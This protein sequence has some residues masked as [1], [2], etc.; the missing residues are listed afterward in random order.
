MIKALSGDLKYADPATR[1][2]LPFPSLIELPVNRFLWTNK[3]GVLHFEFMGRT[4]FGE[5]KTRTKKDN[6]TNAL[7]TLYVYGT[8]GS[9][10]SHLIAA[11][12]CQL[13]CLGHRVLYLPD[14]YFMLMDPPLAIR[15]ALIF[16]FHD[17]NDLDD[18]DMFDHQSMLNFISGK[19]KLWII[20]D[21]LNALEVLGK[22]DG[23][24][25]RKRDVRA[26]LD[27]MQPG[28]PYVL[29]ASANEVSNREVTFKQKRTDVLTVYGGL[30]NVS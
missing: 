8:S 16:A 28:H 23:L 22:D 25:D 13:I 18:V 20:V 19:E 29:S 7:E 10:K 6:F 3:N 21:Q 11:F 1:V 27:R 9:G 24:N 30:T 4:I 14:C 5:L 2:L 17:T 26:M 12:V 15:K